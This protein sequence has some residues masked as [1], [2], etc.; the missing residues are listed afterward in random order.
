MFP[1]RTDPIRPRE[2]LPKNI[3]YY[4][5]IQCQ[6][7]T[8][9]GPPPPR[10]MTMHRQPTTSKT[11]RRRRR[12]LLRNKTHPGHLPSF[13]D[14]KA[15]PTLYHRSA[16]G[17]SPDLGKGVSHKAQGKKLIPGPRPLTPAALMPRLCA[18]VEQITLPRTRESLRAW[19]E[20]VVGGRSR[21]SHARSVPP[22]RAHSSEKD[23]HSRG[24]SRWLE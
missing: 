10:R 15:P 11:R 17:C 4:T 7:S 8:E 20:L 16:P 19:P 14:R 18:F 21:G 13:T 24:R 6:V 22:H 23:K 1:Y 3:F 12:G 9:N 2:D 5:V